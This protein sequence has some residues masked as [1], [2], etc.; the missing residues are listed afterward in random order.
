ML[1]FAER[2]ARRIV[3]SMSSLFEDRSF[4]DSEPPA[5]RFMRRISPSSASTRRAFLIDTCRRSAPTGLTTK[6]SAPARIAEMTASI[7]PC[8]VWTMVGT[9]RPVSRSRVSTAMPSRSGHDEVENHQVDRRR[10]VRLEPRQR[11]VAALGRLRGV[12]EAPHERL[13]QP[14]LDRVVVNDQNGAGHRTSADERATLPVRPADWANRVNPGLRG[15]VKAGQ[16]PILPCGRRRALG[17]RDPASS[18]DHA[19]HAERRSR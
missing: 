7:E 9:L 4:S 13:E 18:R 5:W 16:G 1:D 19:R 6:S 8:A 10:L 15:V 3:R 11:L 17:V 2:S 14:A 12:A